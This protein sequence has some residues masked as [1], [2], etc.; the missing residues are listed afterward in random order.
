M[1][2]LPHTWP[3]H[4]AVTACWWTSW[5]QCGDW[6]LKHPRSRLGAEG[7]HL[8]PWSLQEWPAPHAFHTRTIGYAD[9]VPGFDHWWLKWSQHLALDLVPKAMNLTWHTPGCHKQPRMEPFRDTS[10]STFPSGRTFCEW[11][12][13]SGGWMKALLQSS[14]PPISHLR[15]CSRTLFCSG[16]KNGDL[17]IQNTHARKGWQ[18]TGMFTVWGGPS[19]RPLEDD[20]APR[21]ASHPAAPDRR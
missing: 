5:R 21:W 16:E 17:C 19:P 20:Q 8:L 11:V 13:R 14:K 15:V 2:V 9:A 6:V 3:V 12:P 18:L 7:R 1:A 4:P 10:S